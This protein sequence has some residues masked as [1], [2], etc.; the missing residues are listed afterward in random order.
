MTDRPRRQLL[1][2]GAA[3]FG[4][5][6]LAGCTVLGN[7]APRF[8]FFVI[9]D[10][11]VP[12]AAPAAAP[13]RLDRTLLLTV[14]PTPALFD[15][16]RIVFTRDGAGRAYYQYS[17]WSERPA[18]RVL[19]LTEAR[20]TAGGGFRAVAQTLAGVRGD[21]VLSL[22]L[23]DM[24]HDDSVSPGVMRI[25]V[26]AE[27]LDWRTRTLAARRSFSR[28]ATVGSRDARGAARAASVAVTELLDELAA[29][30]EASVAA[31]PA[32]A[33]PAATRA[34]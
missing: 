33:A 13:P 2:A 4:G 29:W 14:G 10:L 5:T 15:S 8:D 11:R 9:E 7:D 16:D 34:P 12:P 31:I 27:L 20:L 21:Q 1:R 22:R 18:R 19:A 24:T 25:S 26:T 23:D 30:V 32:G 17:N 6:A 28:T 3:A